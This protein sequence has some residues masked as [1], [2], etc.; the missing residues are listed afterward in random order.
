MEREF[1]KLDRQQSER[2]SPLAKVVRGGAVVAGL[3]LLATASFRA[4]GS[5]RNDEVRKIERESEVGSNGF[6]VR[7]EESRVADEIIRGQ[8]LKYKPGVLTEIMVDGNQQ[9]FETKINNPVMR[10][11]GLTGRFYGYARICGAVVYPID[12]VF[13]QP[14]TT[15]TFTAPGGST[16]P[17]SPEAAFMLTEG[18][19]DSGP[20]SPSAPYSPEIAE[21]W[22]CNNAAG[23][24][25]GQILP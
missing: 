24:P 12:S 22:H 14:D 17:I 18:L 9:R 11:D 10:F 16:Q 23:V 5:T 7:T 8:S 6:R 19:V 13:G 1:R 3:A 2:H 25:I 4:G 15:V 21:D 20:I